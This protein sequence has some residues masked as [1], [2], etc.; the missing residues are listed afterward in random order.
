MTDE[1][2]YDDD[3]LGCG[4]LRITGYEEHEDGSATM[5]MEC[6]FYTKNALIEAG[7]LSI[8]E[9]AIGKEDKYDTDTDTRR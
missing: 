5:Y 4:D 7:L 1:Q 9:K 6:S 8:L 2:Q 3:G